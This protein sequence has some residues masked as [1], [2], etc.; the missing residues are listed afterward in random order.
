MAGGA[1]RRADRE[2]VQ[3]G[4]RVLSGCP[5]L[6][7]RKW[8]PHTPSLGHKKEAA[9]SDGFSCKPMR[10]PCLTGQIQRRKRR[11]KEELVGRD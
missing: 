5:W 10:G 11:R 1:V 4:P 7:L 3:L 2:V 6:R 8:S 9:V